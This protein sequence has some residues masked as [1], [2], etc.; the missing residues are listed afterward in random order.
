MPNFKKN[1]SKFQMKGFDAGKGTE[2]GKSHLYKESY[3]PLSKVP[4]VDEYGKPD[5]EG[6][7]Y[8]EPGGKD[9][10]QMYE[11][12]KSGKYGSRHISAGTPAWD[13]SEGEKEEGY[14]RYSNLPEGV[15]ESGYGIDRYDGDREAFDKEVEEE[16]RRDA[17]YRE[18]K[19]KGYDMSDMRNIDKSML[20]QEEI[21]QMK[22]DAAAKK[23]AKE[24][25]KAD[26]E[27][28]EDTED[29][30]GG[31][32]TAGKEKGA[33]R[34]RRDIRKDLRDQGYSRKEARQMAR[35]EIPKR[36]KRNRL[37]GDQDQPGQ[38]RW[39]Q[40]QQ[41]KKYLMETQGMSRKEAARQARREI[42]KRKVSLGFLQKK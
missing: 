22:A 41:R 40:R 25:A 23:E 1:T 4:F 19:E 30:T 3:S 16:A 13:I 32:H 9:Y 2:M 21:D 10:D 11:D 39:K 20:S 31:Y 5:F 36:G 35:E 18:L 17:A 33:W 42:E 15:H 38:G 27:V 29:E 12:F 7:V 14:D 6:N 28:T 34:Q 26:K 8:A 24:Q 37:P